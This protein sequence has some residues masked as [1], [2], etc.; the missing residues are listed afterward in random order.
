MKNTK[1][2]VYE[3]AACRRGSRELHE[4]IYGHGNRQVCIDYNI[5][6]PLCPICHGAAHD[7]WTPHGNSPLY[8]FR[9]ADMKCRKIVMDTHAIAR[10]L[11]EEYLKQDYW[12]ILAAVKSKMNRHHLI[13]IREECE[14]IIKN[15]IICKD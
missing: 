2:L 10:Y 4:L 15:S 12:Q 8:R 3:C 14:K 9:K 6:A 13:M 11:C 7:K 5:Q 1:K